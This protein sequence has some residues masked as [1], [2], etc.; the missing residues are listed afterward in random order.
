MIMRW[1]GVRMMSK[2][3]EPIR[4]RGVGECH[5]MRQGVMGNASIFARELGD[6]LLMVEL[7]YSHY[8]R[9]AVNFSTDQKRTILHK[10]VCLLH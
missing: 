8:Q 10:M 4:L 1:W 2:R 9:D 5:N 7:I 3:W 6:A